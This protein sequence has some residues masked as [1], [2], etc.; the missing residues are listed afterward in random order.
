MSTHIMGWA[1][2]ADV[3]DPIAKLV[4]IALADHAHNDGTNAWPSQS[5]IAEYVGCSDR[6][7]RTKLAELESAGV[8]RRGD[9]AVVSHLPVN[10]RPVVW[11]VVVS[12][13]DRKYVPG[14]KS[15]RAE[16]HGTSGRKLSS[17]NPPFEPPV[18]TRGG[19]THHTRD[20]DNPTPWNDLGGNTPAPAAR[21]PLR[22][23]DRCPDHQHDGAT[24]PCG[25]CKVARMT[26]EASLRDAVRAEA[27]A[28]RLRRLEEARL[29]REEAARCSLCDDDGRDTTGM[30]CSHDPAVADR[31]R[32]GAA[33]ARAVLGTTTTTEVQG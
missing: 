24:P 27:E 6:T 32:R 3:G 4:L 31:A 29:M 23:P 18:V 12:E 8:I 22:Y 7:V 13:T 26:H 19:T 15:V 5:T 25:G 33:A 28:E 17:D 14:G 9:Q 20:D 10:R 11:D 21:P 2:R 30:P 1:L 16:A